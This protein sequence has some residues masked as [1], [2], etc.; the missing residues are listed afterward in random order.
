MIRAGGSVKT[1]LEAA[2]QAVILALDP[3]ELDWADEARKAGRPEPEVAQLGGPDG[4]YRTFLANLWDHRERVVPIRGYS[5]EKVYELEALGVRPDLVFIDNDKSGRELPALGA[6]FPG[7]IVCGDDWN[8]GAEEGYPIRRP[9]REFCRKHGRYL[10]VCRHTWVTDT[11][12]PPLRYHVAR[13]REN[14]GRMRRR[15]KRALGLRPRRR[16]G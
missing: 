10:K 11:R 4:G 15:L 9:V 3:W 14:Y 6:L 16:A 1:W 5:P 8:W 13:A 2:P 7:A 12:R